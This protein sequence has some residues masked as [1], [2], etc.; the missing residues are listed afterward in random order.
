MNKTELTKVFGYIF[1]YGKMAFID[2]YNGQAV[3]GFKPAQQIQR[4]AS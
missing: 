1:E 3:S 2:M 4:Q